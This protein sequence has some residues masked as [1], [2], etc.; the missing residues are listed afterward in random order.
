MYGSPRHTKAPQLHTIRIFADRLD[1][2]QVSS[3]C[4]LV[5]DP[6]CTHRC[7]S[8]FASSDNRLGQSRDRSSPIQVPA[9]LHAPPIMVVTFGCLHLGH[10]IAF[11]S[12]GPSSSDLQ[13]GILLVESSTEHRDRSSN[14]VYATR[15]SLPGHRYLVHRVSWKFRTCHAT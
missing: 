9:R 15:P 1:L 4:Q 5:I 7:R 10:P 13:A 6:A 2:F 3:L 14:I 8:V 12:S 11:S